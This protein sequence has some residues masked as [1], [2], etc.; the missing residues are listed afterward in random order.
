MSV[1]RS[2]IPMI[3]HAKGVCFKE[4]GIRR[5]IKEGML[6]PGVYQMEERRRIRGVQAGYR[7]NSSG[8]ES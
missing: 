7:Q 4:L 1:E 8:T 2:N 3:H 6:L 5:W